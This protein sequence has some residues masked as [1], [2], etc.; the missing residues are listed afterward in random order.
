MKLKYLNI[1]IFSDRGTALIFTLLSVGVMMAI[2]FFASSIFAIK[3]RL[4]LG[5]G[6]SVTALYAAESAIEWQLYNSLRDPD[7]TSPSLGNGATF[8]IVSPPGTLP[9]K[10][11][12]KFRG[13][14]RA[15]EVSF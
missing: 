9:I 1:E 10:V 5:F 11:V 2:V 8:T 14:S 6:D 4:S 7:A 15:V 13:V 3:L 12:G